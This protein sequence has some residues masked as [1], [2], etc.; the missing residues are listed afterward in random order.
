MIHFSNVTFGYANRP[1]MLNDINLHIRSGEYVAFA[2]RNGAGK[3]TIARL[4]N[5]LLLPTTGQV[6]FN[7]YVTSNENDLSII[8]Q[9]IGM[10]FQN[11]EN[12][13][14]ASTVFEDIAFGLQNVCVPTEDIK[15]HVTEALRQVGMLDYYNSDVFSL[16]GGQKQ[17]IAI[18][19]VL[20]MGPEVIVF[21]ES[22]SMLD[23]EGKDQ[24]ALLMGE[25]HKQGI[26]IVTIT[27]DS[28]EIAAS[29]RVIVLDQ[30]DICYDGSPEALF[31]GEYWRFP[32]VT[33]PFVVEAREALNREGLHSSSALTL[34]DL[35]DD[36]CK[37]N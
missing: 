20:A 16:S 7:D 2:G 35:V 17:R 36:L 31:Q 6:T 33:A 25:L 18:A 5:G 8:R 10:I 3:S 22:T 14:V 9:R 21:D 26:T 27:H 13:I 23:P 29:S 15:R 30:G 24:I 34:E 28:E 4:M 12:Q 11:P 1:T 32:G 19:G 37:L